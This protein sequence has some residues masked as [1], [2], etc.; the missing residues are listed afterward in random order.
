MA[1]RERLA[2]PRGGGGGVTAIMPADKLWEL[3]LRPKGQGA[4]GAK[5][6][7]V[8]NKQN[9][10][11]VQK[12]TLG[13]T[14]RTCFECVDVAH[15]EHLLKHRASGSS[16]MHPGPPLPA[17]VQHTPTARH[18][19]STPFERKG[20]RGR[21]PMRHRLSRNLCSSQPAPRKS[22]RTPRSGAGGDDLHPFWGRAGSARPNRFRPR[23]CV[24]R[25]SSGR[26]ICR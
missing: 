16:D 12:P 11:A 21:R 4:Q 20:L 24:D 26:R 23:F 13:G 10:G 6:C 9:A 19:R 14:L 7:S 8:A 18:L 17:R 3:P 1:S 15:K 22:L 5:H 2:R 25:R